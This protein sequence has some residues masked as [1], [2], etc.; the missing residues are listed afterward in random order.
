MPSIT[1]S[2]RHWWGSFMLI[3]SMQWRYRLDLHTGCSPRKPHSHLEFSCGITA[4][5]QMHMYEKSEIRT[6]FCNC[7][8]KIGT[9]CLRQTGKT[10]GEAGILQW[11]RDNCKSKPRNS[12][13]Q[14]TLINERGPRVCQAG[15]NGPRR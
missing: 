13:L 8:Q 11:S 6:K 10:P 4:G 2:W 5:I 9:N 3:V 12:H 1:E 14:K 7:K 15:T